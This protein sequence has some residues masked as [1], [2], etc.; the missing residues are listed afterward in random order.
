VGERLSV[1][2]ESRVREIRSL[3]SMK[4]DVETESWNLDCGTANR[5]GRQ[6]LR[7]TYRHRATSRLYDH[8]RSEAYARERFLQRDNCSVSGTRTHSEVSWLGPRRA[9]IMQLDLH[10]CNDQ[11][12]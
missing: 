10:A 12:C 3:G 8:L 11:Q 1:L 6:Q 2:S 7:G 9:R 5:K 4:R